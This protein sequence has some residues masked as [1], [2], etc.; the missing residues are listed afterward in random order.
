MTTETDRRKIAGLA[1][2]FLD[3]SVDWSTFAAAVH[4]A[5]QDDVIDELGSLMTH[6]PPR[7]GF[8]GLSENQY[9]RYVEDV[10]AAIRRLE[11]SGFEQRDEGERG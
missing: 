8:G 6:M 1:R 7:G 9:R 5:D 10:L 4:E 3:G 11:N 2:G